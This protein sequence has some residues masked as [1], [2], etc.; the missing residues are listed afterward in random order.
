MRVTDSGLTLVDHG[1]AAQWRNARDR[2]LGSQA[3]R[4]QRFRGLVGD[5]AI[6]ADD[7]DLNA[8]GLRNKLRVLVAPFE[9]ELNNT[10]VYAI[11][12]ELARAAPDLARLLKAARSMGLQ[13]ELTE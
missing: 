3:A 6:L 9:S 12:Q 13:M 2:A 7:E 8:E 10:Q 5:L 1:I 4:L 11:R